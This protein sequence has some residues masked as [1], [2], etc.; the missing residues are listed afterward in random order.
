MFIFFLVCVA[1]V[2]KFAATLTDEDKKDP[3]TIEGR[4]KTFC[5]GSKSKENRFVSIK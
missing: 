5:K 1:T 4:F 3:K 2:N